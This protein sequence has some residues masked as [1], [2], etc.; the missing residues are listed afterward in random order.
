MEAH[1]RMLHTCIHAYM[2]TCIHA[3][4]HIFIH[5]HMHTYT[6]NSNNWNIH[7][8]LHIHHL[9]QA[10]VDSELDL[11]ALGLVLLDLIAALRAVKNHEQELPKA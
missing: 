7:T 11:A 8:Y 3:Y 5:K 10:L 9:V 1:V 4:I 6:H 2:H